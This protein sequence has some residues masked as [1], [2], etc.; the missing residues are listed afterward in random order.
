M[1]LIYQNFF[2]SSRIFFI[3]FNNFRLWDVFQTK[4]NKKMKILCITDTHGNIDQINKT[5]TNSKQKID[6]W[7]KYK[8]EFKKS[9]IPS[10]K[11]CNELILFFYSENDFENLSDCLVISAHC[12]KKRKRYK[13]FFLATM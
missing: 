9:K 8:E 6:F 11:L 4:K 7:I 13:L 2:Y 1:Y 5:I 10:L 12:Y 3:I